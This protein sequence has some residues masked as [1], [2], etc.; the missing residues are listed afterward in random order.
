[1]GCR[2]LR[3]NV[4]YIDINIDCCLLYI[5]IENMRKPMI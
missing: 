4:Y 2:N 3:D 1:M 5:W